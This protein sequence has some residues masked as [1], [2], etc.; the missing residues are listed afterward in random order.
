MSNL[1]SPSP[2]EKGCHIDVR[3]FTISFNH[4]VAHKVWQMTLRGENLSKLTIHPGQFV[5]IRC[6]SSLFPLL[7]RPIS[8]CDVRPDQNELD[9]I[10]R[11]EGEGTRYLSQ[12]KRGDRLDLLGP[13]GTGFPIEK[14]RAGEHVA[15]IGGGVGVPPLYYLSKSL[16][17][18]GVTVTHLLGFNTARDIFLREEFEALGETKIATMDGSF[19]YQG[20]VTDLLPTDDLPYS[21][22]YACGP[23]PMLK[24]VEQRL[25][26]KGIE[27]YISVEQRM[28]CGIGA[29]LA[30]VIPSTRGSSYKKVCTDGPVFS[31]GEVSL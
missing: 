16:R 26:G 4:P 25:G 3:L 17:Q 24:A 27:V 20:Y 13:L 5:H 19:G 30:C 8:I 7:R 22:V 28:G 10:Y 15:V 2:K 11:V 29:C 1:N 18:K 14:R 9:L 21:A 31:L 23:L 12:L 6:G